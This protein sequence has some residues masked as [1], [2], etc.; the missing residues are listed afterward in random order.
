MPQIV[1]VVGYGPVQFPDGMSKAEMAEA[2][3]K[4][5]PLPSDKKE[6]PTITKE[7]L[8]KKEILG[9]LPVAAAVGFAKPF[10]GVLQYAGVNKPAEKLEEI[11][12][13]VAESG[14]VPAQ[15]GEFV[16]ELANPIPTKS[17]K[18]VS[19]VLPKALDK[20]VLGKSA[21]IGAG[22]AAFSPT[23]VT[24]AS[25]E[26]FLSQ[27]AK[28]MGQAGLL[29]GAMG[30][31]TQLALSPQVSPALQE[32]QSMGMK[33]FTPG[34]LASQIPVIGKGIR[35]TEQALTSLPLTGMAIRGGLERSQQDFNRAVANRVL[36]PMG[37]SVPKTIK[38][39][40]ELID[41]VNKRITDAYDKITPQL[42]LQNVRYN[43]PT[44]ASGFTTTTKVFNDKLA[45][46]TRGLPS[47]TAANLSQAVRDEF[48]RFIIDPLAVK[49]S[50][51]GK[52]FRDAE[53]AL[54]NVAY[55]YMRD[56]KTYDVG[57]ALR[58]LQGKIREELATQNPK[59]A[60]ELTGIHQAFRRHL[61]FER[62]AGYV[63]AEGRVFSPAQLESAVKA[64]TKG[65]GAFASGQGLLYP[66]S[67]AALEIMGKS[68]PS[69]GTAERLLTAGQAGRMLGLGGGEAAA[70][71]AAPQLLVTVPAA[72]A[73]YNNPVMGA[74]TTMATK[75]PEMMRRAEPPLT[76]LMSRAGG[77]T[78]PLDQAEQ[79]LL[80]AAQPVY[81]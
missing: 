14:G 5:P 32:L 47:S 46:V 4:L 35:A 1:E 42:K 55:Q 68:M 49:G 54:G 15:I 41:Y 18:L 22:Q 57:V 40:E 69:S 70:A 73:I 16:G 2:L 77:I 13:F 80:Q 33:Y 76:N 20:S 66:E 56:P 62:A 44:S 7:D 25:Y 75:R 8:Y 67:Q 12:K 81:P 36:E 52:E 58:E 10:A 50:L 27:K 60:D 78:S 9:S 59:F 34:Q 11:S 39:G 21:A 3:S 30:K 53:K 31:G 28:Q 26:D 19:K 45:E 17:G 72:A 51:T 61:P 64:E 37:E 63:G 48:N 71:Y 79:D 23:E 6:K 74:L 43:D 65:K 29:S 24:P 38:S